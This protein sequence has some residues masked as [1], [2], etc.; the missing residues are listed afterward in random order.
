MRSKPCLT[1]A[2]LHAMADACRA[3]AELINVQATIAIVDDGG[4]LFYLERMDH[5]MPMTTKI[6]TQKAQSAS[7]SRRPPKFWQERAAASAVFLRLPEILPIQGGVP[8]LLNDDCVG[9]IGV[10]GG[11]GDED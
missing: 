5:A 11:K 8:I 3:E 9:A 7:V 2:D 4:R 6:A 10:S 1:S